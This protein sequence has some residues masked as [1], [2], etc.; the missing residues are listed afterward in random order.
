G[1]DS[2]Y[3]EKRLTRDMDWVLG[4]FWWPDHIDIA[5]TLHRWALER[6]KD[7]IDRER[8]YQDR[9]SIS[10]REWLEDVQVNLVAEY[11]RALVKYFLQQALELPEGQR[12]RAIDDIIE[13]VVADESE[14]RLDVW[15]DRAFS[16]TQ[17][18][19]PEMRMKMFAMS[20]E[21]L[22]QL[23]DPLIEFAKATY[24][25]RE[26]QRNRKKK[27]SGAAS[28]LEPKLISA[29]AEWKSGELYPDAN[30]TM[31]VNFGVVKGYS[32]QEGIDY[33]CFTTTAGVLKKETGADPFIVPE[34]LKQAQP[35]AS[36]SRYAYAPVNDVP[37]NFLTTNDATG[38]NSGSP[39]IDGKGSLVGLLFDCNYEGIAADYLFNSEVARSISV[40][41]RYV[42]FVIDD[43][44][45]LDALMD[46]LTL[47]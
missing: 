31:R 5:F 14:S 32:P 10:T 40:D 11:D 7:D 27:H 29:Y 8:G 3:G 43:V 12:I 20:S 37:V 24:E 13:A 1:L 23:N 9:D 41:I 4:M 30:G 15:L 2:L 46:E 26:A 25:E 42:L 38:G 45:H 22:D 18:G 33:N 17:V 19:D 35:A 28:R 34:L 47:L 16:N 21:E 44:Y 39:V 6:K 36:S